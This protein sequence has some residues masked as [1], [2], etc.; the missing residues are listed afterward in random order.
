MKAFDKIFTRLIKVSLEKLGDISDVHIEEK[1]HRMNS[2]FLKFYTDRLCRHSSQLQAEL[3]S[4]LFLR[5]KDM[6]AIQSDY[7]VYKIHSPKVLHS[8]FFTH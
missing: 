8:N 5:L 2:I 6:Q 3:F 4:W 1:L 7:I